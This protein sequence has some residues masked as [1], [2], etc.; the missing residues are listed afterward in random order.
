MARGETATMVSLAYS[1]IRGYGSSHPTIAELRVGYVDIYI[2][3]PY[4]REDEEDGVYLGDMLLTEVETVNSIARD[5]QT[6]RVQFQLGYGLCFGQNELKAIAMSIL[7]SELKVGGPAPAQDEEFVMV[8]I[9]SVDSGGFVSHL[10]LPH[11][12]G[13]NSKMDVLRHGVDQREGRKDEHE[14]NE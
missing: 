14:D 7:D 5:E 9:D 2:P 13:F 6:G 4:D 1:A 12:V 11:Y 10:K 8:H 3:H